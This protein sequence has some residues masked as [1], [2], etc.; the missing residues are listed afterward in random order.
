MQK[1]ILLSLLL[2]VAPARAAIISSFYQCKVTSFSPKEA[3]LQCPDVRPKPLRT[4]REW[5]SPE[6]KINMGSTVAFEITPERLKQ[7]AQAN[8]RHAAPGKGSR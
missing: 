3:W 2:G 6:Q 5:I 4:P 7:W 1:L 8:G